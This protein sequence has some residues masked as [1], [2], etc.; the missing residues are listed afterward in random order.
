MRAKRDQFAQTRLDVAE[1][2]AVAVE[3]FERMMSLGVNARQ[4]VAHC[5]VQPL[6][7]VAA[8]NRDQ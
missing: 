2:R 7:W 5:V 8:D 1:A 6:W 4:G 3:V